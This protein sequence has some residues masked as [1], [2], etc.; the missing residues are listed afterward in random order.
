MERTTLDELET[1]TFFKCEMK[2]YFNKRYSKDEPALHPFVAYCRF[3]LEMYAK[4]PKANPIDLF[5]AH[6]ELY[7]P[8]KR[9]TAN[10]LSK[11]GAKRFASLLALLKIDTIVPIG[12]KVLHEFKDDLATYNSRIS[13]VASSATNGA[14]KAYAFTNLDNV[15][16]INWSPL[17]LEQ[18]EFL[19]KLATKVGYVSGIR[20]VMYVIYM[21]DHWE[22]K[23]AALSRS[24]KEAGMEKGIASRLRG[25]SNRLCRKI[26]VA[27]ICPDTNCIFF[28]RCNPIESKENEL[29]LS[30]QDGAE[31]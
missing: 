8:Y 30:K 14:L 24:N 26:A 16:A 7:K 27:S 6:Q 1:L 9:Q 28:E 10:W 11:Y 2:H 5:V 18:Q 21:N 25:M 23:R 19:L 12:G 20:P 17:H 15:H 3:I 22:F 31:D 13:M 29:K 4:D